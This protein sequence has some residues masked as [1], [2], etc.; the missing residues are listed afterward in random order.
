M[1]AAGR[2][3][4]RLPARR[5]RRPPHRHP[6]RGPERDRGRRRA[7]VVAAAALVT[8]F[9]FGNGDA[10]FFGLPG[11]LTPGHAILVMEVAIALFVVVIS[12]RN[13]RIAAPI[14]ALAQLGIA[15]LPGPRRPPAGAGPAAALLVRPADH[16]DGAR[17]RDHRA[18]DLRPRPRLHARLPALEPDDR[19]PAHRR[20]S[21]CSS[22]SSRRCSAS[23]SPTTCRCCWSS[24]RSRRS[25]RSS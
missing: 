9:A 7:V 17:H 16:G 20:S 4:G 22:C 8:V 6:G 12:L 18:A 23:W 19:R 14:M 5:Q 2:L 1:S 25:A 10:V 24:G 15:A 21:S 3:P 11:G 13:G